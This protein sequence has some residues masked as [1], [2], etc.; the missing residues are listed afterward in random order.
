MA[1]SSVDETGRWVSRLAGGPLES[2]ARRSQVGL[3]QASHGVHAG[4][5]DHKEEH[6]WNRRRRGA[7]L[8]AARHA[9]AAMPLL[10]SGLRRRGFAERRPI[11]EAFVDGRLE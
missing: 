7:P 9:A 11:T 8:C 1:W 2:R 3:I 4:R 5:V 10:V 6:A